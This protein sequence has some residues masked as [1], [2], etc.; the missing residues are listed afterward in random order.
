MRMSSSILD[1]YRKRRWRKVTINGEE[2]TIRGM[3]KPDKRR[4][5]AMPTPELQDAL[6]AAF[7]MLNDD[8]T[9]LFSQNEGETDEDF[10]KR[11]EVE[12]ED[13][14]PETR[15]ELANASIRLDKYP[16]MENLIKN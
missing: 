1:R 16:P 13:I 3:T 8:A 10:A 2:F 7:I 11:V 5:A 4:V 9:F 15:Y 12:I 6:S 14:P